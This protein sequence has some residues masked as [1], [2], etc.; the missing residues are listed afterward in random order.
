MI[1]SVLSISTFGYIAKTIGP[2]DVLHTLLNN[3]KVQDRQMRLYT[4]VAIVFMS[5]YCAP[6]LNFQNGILNA[7]FF[8]F[9]YTDHMAKDYIYVVASFLGDTL[10]DKDQV[11]HQMARAVVKHPSLGVVH[12]VCEDVLFH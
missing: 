3:L 11:H 9:E 10:L 1:L 4:T 5:E 8:M 7:L 6:E 12:L 2:R